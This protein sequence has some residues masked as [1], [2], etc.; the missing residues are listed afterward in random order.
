MLKRGRDYSHKFAI[1]S[2]MKSFKPTIIT[3]Y[4][5]LT[6]KVGTRWANKGVR[7]SSRL[8]LG[9]LALP[10]FFQ[11][12]SAPSPFSISKKKNLGSFLFLIGQTKQP[13]RKLPSSLLFAEKWPASLLFYHHTLGSLFLLNPKKWPPF[14]SNQR[15]LY[16]WK[17]LD[18]GCD[19]WLKSTS[20]AN[21][22]WHW[23]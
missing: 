1:F 16:S 2:L 21:S 4:T 3:G 15:A 20:A 18:F 9:S 19:C 13:K 17:S 14:L 5:T 6:S 12:P 7:Q 8:S 22:C 10:S 11:N 23:D